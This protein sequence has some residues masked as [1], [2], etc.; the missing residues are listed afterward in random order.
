MK[1]SSKLLRKETVKFKMI[2]ITSTLEIPTEQ[3]AL[4]GRV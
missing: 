2:M 1:N 3:L 4:E